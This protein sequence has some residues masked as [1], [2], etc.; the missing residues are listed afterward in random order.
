MRSTCRF[1]PSLFLSEDMCRGGGISALMRVCAIRAS[2]SSDDSVF[3][4]RKADYAGSKM[5]GKEMEMAIL[6][7]L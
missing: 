4:S 2:E 5:K 7:E 3:F 6:R 1:F